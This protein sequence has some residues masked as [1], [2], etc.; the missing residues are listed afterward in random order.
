M[1]QRPCAH[2]PPEDVE[3]DNQ[4]SP[5][6]PANT[7]DGAANALPEVSTDSGTR[8]DGIRGIPRETRQPTVKKRCNDRPAPTAITTATGVSSR[9]AGESEGSRVGSSVPDRN[10]PGYTRTAF[11]YTLVNAL[12]RKRRRGSDS[13]GSTT[14]G[15]SGGSRSPAQPAVGGAKGGGGKGRF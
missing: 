10:P 6:A 12:T 1:K 8:D 13:A 4:Q 3:A 2:L 15:I 5:H 14:T 9:I 7:S 11:Y